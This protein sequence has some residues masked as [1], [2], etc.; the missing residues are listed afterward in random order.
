MMKTQK[1]VERRYPQRQRTKPKHLD[2]YV[3]DEG[4]I[5]NAARCSIDYCYRVADVPQ[6]YREALA[7]PESLQWQ[8]AMKEE[9]NALEE[10]TLLNW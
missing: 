7:S 3:M 9:M 10:N 1:E 4:D 5:S 2:D 6:T 8:E